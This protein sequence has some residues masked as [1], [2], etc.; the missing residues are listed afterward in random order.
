MINCRRINTGDIT[1][2]Y[3]NSVG[4]TNF[5]HKRNLKIKPNVSTEKLQSARNAAGLSTP[6]RYILMRTMTQKYVLRASAMNMGERTTHQLIRGITPST[7]RTTRTSVINTAV[8][9]MNIWNK[10]LESKYLQ[11]ILQSSKLKYI[12]EQK[13]DLLDWVWTNFLIWQLPFLYIATTNAKSKN[14]ISYKHIKQN[15]IWDKYCVAHKK[16]THLQNSDTK[17]HG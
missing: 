5:L 12:M 14:I 6:F 8:S 10:N 17:P 13:I 11:C 16:K 15:E 1:A 7:R 9:H 2:E 3:S 4:F